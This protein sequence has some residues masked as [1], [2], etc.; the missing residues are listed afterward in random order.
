MGWGERKGR[1]SLTRLS[2][3]FFFS[4]PP[5]LFSVEPAF[6]ADAAALGL[7]AL[8]GWS[9]A[10]DPVFDRP[11]V[12]GDSVRGSLAVAQAIV[13]RL[14]SAAV[15]R[16]WAGPNMYTPDGRPILGPMPGLPGMHA[17][18]CNTYG[19]TL[20]PLCGLLV[21]EMLAGQPAS[22]YT[23]AFSPQRFAGG[24]VPSA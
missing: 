20:G 8:L 9:A 22:F 13:P 14:A 19:F 1:P 3:F 15:I 21:A 6:P 17:A 24:S 11:A 18:V 12:L 16:T 7:A 2:L 4:T 23:S 10:R 5:D